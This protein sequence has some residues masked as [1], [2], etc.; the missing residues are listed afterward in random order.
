[1]RVESVE[2]NIGIKAEILCYFR[3]DLLPYSRLIIV[4]MALSETEVSE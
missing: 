4:S 1:M 2:K 3:A